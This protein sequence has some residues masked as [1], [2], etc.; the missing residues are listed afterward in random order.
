MY[1]TIAELAGPNG[2]GL[3][4]FSPTGQPQQVR[5]LDEKLRELV[6][7]KDFGALGD[8]STDDTAAS[9]STLPGNSRPRARPWCWV[10]AARSA[11]KPLRASWAAAEAAFWRVLST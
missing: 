8:G 3:V 4:G 6:S 5:A 11:S 2:S 9:A 10:R 1:V 7:V